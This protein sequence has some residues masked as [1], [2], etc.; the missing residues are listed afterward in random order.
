MLGADACGQSGLVSAQSPVEPPMLNRRRAGP[1]ADR[2]SPRPS[3]MEKLKVPTDT[4]E[5]T[6]SPAAPGQTPLRCVA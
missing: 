5:D 4:L 2:P 6:V 3:P 1:A